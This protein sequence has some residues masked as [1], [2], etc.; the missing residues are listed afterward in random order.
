MEDCYMKI[1]IFA[2]G[3]EQALIQKTLLNW[4]EEA[5]YYLSL[6]IYISQTQFL[7]AMNTQR[8]DAV[9]LSM[10]GV[11][12]MEAAIGARG[13]DPNVPLVW[14]SDDQML[15]IQ[16][17]R[18]HARFFLLRPSKPEQLL[19]GLERCGLRWQKD[20]IGEIT[21]LRDYKTGN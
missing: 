18:L 21:R 8:F 13:M 7:R 11:L 2:D 6:E 17:Y 14:A 10:P 20:K 1:A 4:A 16:S 9:F 12:G 19:E 15:A 5:G 3:E